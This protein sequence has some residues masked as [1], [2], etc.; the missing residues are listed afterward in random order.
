MEA[1]KKD[2]ILVLLRTLSLM[3]EQ[4]LKGVNARMGTLSWSFFSVH[5]VMRSR[6][7]WKVF[8]ITKYFV[9]VC[10]RIFVEFALVLESTHECAMRDLSAW[11]S[12]VVWPGHKLRAPLE[13]QPLDAFHLRAVS[14]AKKCLWVGGIS[15]AN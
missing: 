15:F 5:S 4:A 11:V 8:V 7:R 13:T 10:I 14:I 1:R 9:R 3:P 2:R 12:D 6:L